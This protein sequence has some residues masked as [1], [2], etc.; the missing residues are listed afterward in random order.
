MHLHLSLKC[1]YKI[2]GEFLAGQHSKNGPITSPSDVC[3]S[4]QLSFSLTLRDADLEVM[5]PD[6]GE[7]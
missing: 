7:N 6:L 2:H 5:A 3:S 4:R 1:L